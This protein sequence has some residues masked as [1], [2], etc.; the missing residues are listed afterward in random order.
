MLILFNVLASP[1]AREGDEAVE[2][3][4]IVAARVRLACPLQAEMGS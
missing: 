2:T 4:S 3:N 1:C